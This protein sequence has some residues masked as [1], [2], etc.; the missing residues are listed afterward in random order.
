MCGS[1]A[2]FSRQRRISAEVLKRGIKSLY[3]RRPDGK[4][5][6]KN[7]TPDARHIFL[8]RYADVD[9]DGSSL[10][11]FDVTDNSAFEYDSHG[12]TLQ[13]LG[14]TNIRH[15]GVVSGDF[16]PPDPRVP[17]AAREA[18]TSS[19]VDGS[20][21]IAYNTTLPKGGALTVTLNY[22]RQCSAI[23]RFEPIG[24]RGGCPY[25]HSENSSIQKTQAAKGEKV[26]RTLL[27]SNTCLPRC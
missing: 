12:L 19:T 23:Q 26:C 9:A 16:R 14:T 21:R 5:A 27:A 20:I 11:N 1:V 25:R 18:L 8:A 6:L 17:S 7:N 15:S 10:N 24:S 13:N 3:P 4:R 2:R 22:K